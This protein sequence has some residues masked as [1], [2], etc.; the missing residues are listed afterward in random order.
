[1]TLGN[2]DGVHRGHQRIMRELTEEA[3]ARGAPAVAVTFEPHPIRVLRPDIAP[4]RILTAAQK[5][6]ILT[7]LGIDFLVIIRFTA[8]FSR[9]S[10]EE[11][12]REVLVDKLHAAGLVLGGNFRFGRRRAGNL[13][14]LRVLGRDVG[15][16]VREVA[17]ALH[18]G[19]MISSSRIRRALGE[20]RVDEAAAMLGRPYFLDAR[21]VPGDGRGRSIGYP[22]ANLALVG[23][24]LAAEGVYVS[25]A[26]L[27]SGLYRGMTH[28]GRRPTF[29]SEARVVETHLFDFSEDI[30]HQ[31]LRLYLH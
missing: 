6:E 26:R 15:F 9:K 30:Y 20:G 2:F 13:E 14:T 8:D 4:G 25:T 11:F 19:E 29:A 21:V 5:Q 24:L 18:R 12:I 7:A 31:R 3:R 10:P 16:T 28:V 1:M 22:T 23:D 17:P 27:D